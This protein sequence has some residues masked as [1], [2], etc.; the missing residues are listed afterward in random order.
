MSHYER[1]ATELA[2]I[3]YVALIVLAAAT[4]LYS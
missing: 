3:A 1:F 2:L 4:I